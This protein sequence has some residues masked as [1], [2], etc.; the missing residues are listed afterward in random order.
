VVS[1]YFGK[2]ARKYTLTLIDAYANEVA[3]RVLPVFDHIEQ[4]ADDAANQCWSD[5]DNDRTAFEHGLSVY[6]DLKFVREQVTGLAVAGL[7]HLWERLI[8]EFIINECRS[9]KPTKQDVLP[10]NDAVLKADF[11]KLKEFLK[12]VGWSIKTG[13]FYPDLDYLRLVANVVKHGDGPSC[14]ALLEK[15][16]GM[17]VDFGTRGRTTIGVYLIYHLNRKTFRDLLMQSEN[18]LN[19]F[20]SIYRRC[21]LTVDGTGDPAQAGQRGCA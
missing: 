11:P 7:Y 13:D 10:T 18:S 9:D 15:A 1:L 21:S 16:P 2:P 5:T 20:P 12:S 4:E 14:K 19:N 3:K 17:F 6:S 8:K